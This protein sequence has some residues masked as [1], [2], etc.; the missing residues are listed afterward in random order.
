MDDRFI[1]FGEMLLEMSSDLALRA[2]I[3]GD[4]FIVS[5]FSSSGNSLDCVGASLI[6]LRRLF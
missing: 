1:L 3:V 6:V 4:F 5:A 2:S